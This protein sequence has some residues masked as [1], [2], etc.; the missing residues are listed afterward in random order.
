MMKGKTRYLLGVLVLALVGWIIWH[1]ATHYAYK[2]IWVDLGPIPEARNTPYYAAQKFLEQK[3]YDVKTTGLL[4]EVTGRLDATDTLLLFYDHELE[5]QTLN[6]DIDNWVKQGGHLVL[7]VHYLWDEDNQSSGD[8]YLDDLGVRQYLWPKESENDGDAERESKDA[9]EESDDNS[10][11]SAEF[12]PPTDHADSNDEALELTE[13]DSEQNQEFASADNPGVSGEATETGTGADSTS[14]ESV[15]EKIVP[16]KNLNIPAD[17]ETKTEACNLDYIENVS[18]LPLQQG[19]HPLRIAFEPEYHVE[20]VSGNAHAPFTEAPAHILQYTRGAGKITVLTDYFIFND[21]NIGD[22]DHAFFLWWLAQDSPR[23]W[24]IYD[25]DSDTL[26]SLIWESTPYLCISLLLLL[27]S[28][29]LYR[30]RRFGPILN[31]EHTSRRQLQEHID[32][33]TALMW[34]QAEQAQLIDEARQPVLSKCP[35][36]ANQITRTPRLKRA[37]EKLNISEERLL[38]ALTNSSVED[39]AEFV[40]LIRLLQ[41]LRMTL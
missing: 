11:A 13:E 40:E 1:F 35:L 16:L 3:G 8:V 17:N 23:V 36:V 39:E 37:L 7:T 21:N 6:S 30:G 9:D 41:Q 10:D 28:W 33:S 24:L 20:D 29:L 26:L 27:G 15:Q 25:K 38:W 22:Y 32:A 4:A 2:T 5:Y 18:L 19:S 31:I 14:K 12:E 34:R